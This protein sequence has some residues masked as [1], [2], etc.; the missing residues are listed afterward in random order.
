[1]KSQKT[2]SQKRKFNLG[3]MMIFSFILIFIS[4]N[5]FAASSSF[6][7]NGN[8]MVINSGIG[9]GS[10]IAIVASWTRNKSV[11]WAIFHAFCGWLYVIYYVI[12]R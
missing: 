3:L 5:L 1:M 8:K 6:D 2:L 9:V 11:L 12:T 7:Y 10:I 4:F